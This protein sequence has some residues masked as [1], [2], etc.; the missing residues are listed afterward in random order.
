VIRGAALLFFATVALLAIASAARA[1]FIAG[2]TLA[3]GQ[4]LHGRFI[5]TR[6]LTGLAAPLTSDGSFV[7]APDRGLIWRLEHPVQ[8]TTVITPAG[9][10]QIINGS[11]VQHIEAAKA[12]FIA[13]FY[14]M[15]SGALAGDLTP[16]RRDFAIQTTGDRHSWSTVLTPLRPDDPVAGMVAAIVIT[17][18]KM[19]DDVS[20]RRS[21][22]DSEQLTFLQQMVSP[23]SND[24]ERLLSSKKIA[25]PD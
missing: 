5:Q 7:L 17:G 24:D 18:G 9:V 22:G 2:P 15:L 10:R 19:V 21:N 11:E 16:L 23:L 20:I 13:R 4:T 1:E 3:P 6:R 8:T 25:P 14:A 12:P